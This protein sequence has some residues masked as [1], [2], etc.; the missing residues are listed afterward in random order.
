MRRDFNLNFS[1]YPE[2]VIARALPRNNRVNSKDSCTLIL[3]SNAFCKGIK[4][5]KQTMRKQNKLLRVIT[6]NQKAEKRNCK[7][8]LNFHTLARIH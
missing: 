6:G 5:L 4:R 8:I 2:V 1:C 7:S 3:E